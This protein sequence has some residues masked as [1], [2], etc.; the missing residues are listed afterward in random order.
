MGRPMAMNLARAGADL[1]VCAR[2]PESLAPFRDSGIRATT[3]VSDLASCELVFLCLPDGDVVR[4]V[5]RADAGLRGPGSRVEAIV[6]T[7]TIAHACAVEIARELA[8]RGVA[9]VD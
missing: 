4:E 2:S 1:T 3:Q 9:F 6:D 5:V 7:S 8:V